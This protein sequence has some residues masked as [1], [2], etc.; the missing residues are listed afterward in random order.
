[1]SNLIKRRLFFALSIT[2]SF[3]IPA[4]AIIVRY[5][6][7]NKFLETKNSIKISIIGSAL[8]LILLMTNLK[9][10]MA[11]LDSLDFSIWKCI[12]NGVIKIL[13]VLCIALLVINLHNIIDDLFY[14][15]SWILGCNILA[16]F[17]WDPLYQYYTSEH[18]YDQ[19]QIKI[20]KRST[21]EAV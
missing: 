20:E 12:I 1:M 9:K 2:F 17:V 10:V 7:I 13:P 6:M 16:L 4:T 19:T 5:D 15:I 14:A 3:L 11:Y 21:N 18:L 8:V